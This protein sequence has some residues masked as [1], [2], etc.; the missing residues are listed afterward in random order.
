MLEKTRGILGDEH[1]R[2][3]RQRERETD[4]QQCDSQRSVYERSESEESL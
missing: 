4:A 3:Q 1:S 2:K